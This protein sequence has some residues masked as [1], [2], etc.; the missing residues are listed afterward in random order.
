MPIDFTTYNKYEIDYNKLF[1]SLLN[2][3]VLTTSDLNFKYFNLWKNTL[4]N[5][6][7]EI[8]SRFD[9]IEKIQDYKKQVTIHNESEFFS[10]DF[11]FEPS[12]VKVFI[13]YRVSAL[14]KLLTDTK[15]FTHY[16]DIDISE[17]TKHDSDIAYSKVKVDSNRKFN[18]T[19]IIIVPFLNGH[20]NNLVIDGNHRVAHAIATNKKSIKAIP[21]SEKTLIEHRLFSSSFDLFL[22]IFFNE[23]NHFSN[24][25]GYYN[26]SD[27]ELL[28]RSYIIN[29][30]FRF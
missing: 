12:R 18:D 20:S 4:I 3:N 22:Y 9:S 13:H 2:L 14:N 28:N 21:V 19:P 23:L 16:I 27:I 11:T 1:T 25:K 30:D 17:F 7:K 10:H 29:G 6:D 24:N 5:H 8:V 15:S 26:L